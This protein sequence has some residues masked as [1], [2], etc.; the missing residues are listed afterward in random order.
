MSSGRKV[1]G[2]ISDTHGLLRDSALT[3]LKDSGL[4]IHA[5]DIGNPEIIEQLQRIAPVTAVRGNMDKGV[6]A[7]NL[8]RY[9]LVEVSKEILY[10]IH[11]I[12]EIDLDPVAAGLTVVISG[13]SHRPS[14]IE[15]DGV[16]FLNPGSAGP[17]RFNLPLTVGKLTMEN[18]KRIPEIIDLGD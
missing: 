10:V 6:W 4:L 16:I 17:R 15:K 8:S 1:I 7:A 12:N 9:E 14:I 13:H 2:I 5:G 3:V 11:D 18:G